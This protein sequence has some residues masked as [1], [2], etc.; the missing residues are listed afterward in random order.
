MGLQLSQC[1]E[2]RQELKLSQIIETNMLLSVPDE[3]LSLVMGKISTNPE[4]IESFLQRERKEKQR[5]SSADESVK[6]IYYSLFPSKK[7][8]DSA[9]IRG[10]IGSPDLS[11]L[12]DC[13]SD[14]VVTITPDVIYKGRKNQAPKLKY[15]EHLTGSVTIQIM[16]LDVSRYNETSRLLNR[17]RLFNDW[18]NGLLR[19]VYAYIGD[20]QR[21]FFEELEYARCRILFAKDIANY[22]GVSESTIY[23]ALSN[24]YIQAESIRGRKEIINSKDLIVTPDD[25]KKFIALPVL[26]GVMK[27]EFGIGIAYSDSEIIGKYPGLARRTIAKY[28]QTSDIPPANIRNQEYANAQRTEPYQFSKN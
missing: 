26:N 23:R 25:L 6:A 7:S 27:E 12:E 1:L 14:T 4:I 9:S 19:N 20:V 18:K 21:N 8:G 17:L 5:A 28:R 3:V 16:Q 24:R 2:L 15:S 11:G 22:V 10:I 13:L